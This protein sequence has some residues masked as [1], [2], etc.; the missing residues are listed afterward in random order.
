MDFW[1]RFF[2]L[3]HLVINFN[4]L[5]YTLVVYC[6]PTATMK[7]FVVFATLLAFLTVFVYSHP[8]SSSPTTKAK[9]MECAPNT[10]ENDFDQHVVIDYDYEKHNP[11]NDSLKS[12]A[13]CKTMSKGYHKKK[14]Q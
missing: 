9:G 3:K 8:P 11:N 10:T 7:N 1:W 2:C 14:K 4:L 5:F 6:N 13:S 12:K